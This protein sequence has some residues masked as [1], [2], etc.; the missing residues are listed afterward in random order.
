[1]S[2]RKRAFP[3]PVWLLAFFGA[4]LFAFSVL[5]FLAPGAVNAF[6]LGDFAS[7]LSMDAGRFLSFLPG[8]ETA[9]FITVCCLIAGY[10]M[11]YLL[12]NSRQR[13]ARILWLIP[14]LWLIGGALLFATQ[15]MTLLPL[16]IQSFLYP[17]EYWGLRSTAGQALILFP[18]MLLAAATG[19]GICDT[20]LPETALDLGAS[21]I[22]AFLTLTFPR[23]LPGT[24]VGFS[25]VFLFS[26]GFSLIGTPEL[27]IGFI[28]S[29][30][31]V[32]AILAFLLLIFYW[33]FQ[34]KTRRAK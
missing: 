3:L 23:T 2:R 28:L 31:A 7:L 33:L 16:Y 24:F 19:F 5:W 26:A 17:I 10:P 29:A 8:L 15:W 30:N 22:R 32:L 20:A 14:L 18:L 6:C 12:G 34:H 21:R 11:G 13:T 4:V 25:L 9:L 1:M 27:S